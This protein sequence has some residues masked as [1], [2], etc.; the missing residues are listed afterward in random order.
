MKY[1]KDVGFVIKRRNVGEADKYV[2]LFTKNHGK[3]ELLAK[4]VRKI[5]SRRAGNIE[6]LNLIKFHAVKGQKNYILAEVELIDAF[7]TLKKN[8]KSIAFV[9]LTSELI[10][11]LCPPGQKN[12]EVF[13]LLNNTL[14]SAVLGNVDAT[15]FDFETRLV[16]LLGY[17]DQRRRFRNEEDVR[18]FIEGIIERKLETRTVFKI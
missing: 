16:T 3:Q 10:Y 6:P 9:F 13:D 7:D 8:L 12:K 15:L 2:T 1:L 14:G 18:R 11:K 17:W 4:G 5:T